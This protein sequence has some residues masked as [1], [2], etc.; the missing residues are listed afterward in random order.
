MSTNNCKTVQPHLS[1]YHDGELS[2]GQAA[3]VAKHVRSCEACSAVLNSFESLASD[4]AQDALPAK[5]SDLWQ[6]IERE[7]L[8]ATEPVRLPQRSSIWLFESPYGVGLV[9]LAASVLLLLGF[10][11][12][13]GEERRGR[14]ETGSGGA[15]A[16]HSYDG[17]K[18]MSADHMAEFAG[19]M[20]DYLQQL[21]RDP[22]GAEQMLLAK[23]NGEKV[24]SD[25][26][27]KLVGY[28][29][30]VSGGL[31]DGYSLASTSVLKMPCCTCVK[32]VC[33]R[34]D[35]STLVLFEHDD[36]ETAWFG[37]RP[38]RMAMCGD[39]DCC[40]VDLDSSIAATWKQGTRSVTA[41]GV[42]D[43]A[44]VTTLVKWLEKS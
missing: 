22:G 24:D 20:D 38:S 16:M 32:A 42:R 41:V 17:E 15:I 27:V 31:P 11:L 13:Y 40:L 12:W 4:F 18:G 25:G 36:D 35:G 30:I 14:K 28:Q 7:L 1:A 44:E 8:N 34:S 39:K 29:P 21:L 26:A 19:V 10:G 6:R 23:Y 33:K 5:P 9:S 3:T 37:N 2:A 43:Q